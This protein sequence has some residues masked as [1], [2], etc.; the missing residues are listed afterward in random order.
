MSLC[1]QHTCCIPML[2]NIHVVNP[3]RLEGSVGAPGAGIIVSCESP[4]VGTRKQT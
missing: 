1:V 4:E 3:W 2:Y